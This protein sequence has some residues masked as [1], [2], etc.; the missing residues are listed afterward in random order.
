MS[1]DE[2]SATLVRQM[3]ESGSN[4][5]HEMSIEEA[6][7]VTAELK[8][9]IGPGPQMHSVENVRIAVDG[10]TINARV[11]MPT[12]APRGVI[13]YCHG[14][15]WVVGALD[16]FDTVARTLAIRTGM[17]TVMVDY[18][19]APEHRYPTAVN[20]AWAALQWV[21]ARR[22][23]LARPDAPVVVAGDS[24]GGNLSAVLALR[25][26]DEGGPRVDLQV[27]VYPVVD[28]DVDRDSYLNPENQLRLTRKAMVWF[29]D[30]YAPD[31]VD[32]S[33]WSA[34]PLRADNLEGLAPAIVLTAEHDVLRD[35]GE[36]FARRLSEAG[37]PV[38]HRRFEGQMHGFFTMVGLLPG[39]EAGLAFVAE[40]IDRHLFAH[41][42]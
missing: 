28:W 20:D 3:I 15:G 22:G 21:H 40:A 17:T 27:L 39:S 5:L 23:E 30:H 16:D 32:R 6:R 29:W 19:L 2:A 12:E 31:M 24:S 10:G 37:V 42:A 1:L 9:I 41:H 14:G 35:E 8:D 25:A 13:L 36:E 26:R 18:R 11:L 4:P 38:D 33:A 34:S 7:G